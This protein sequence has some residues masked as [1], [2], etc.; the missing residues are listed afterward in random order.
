MWRSLP[1]FYPTNLTLHDTPDADKPAFGSATAG[2]LLLTDYEAERQGGW[3]KVVTLDGKS[4]WSEHR[5]DYLALSQQHLCFG[6]WTEPLRL[7]PSTPTA[8]SRGWE[9]AR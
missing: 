6:K 4:G 7:P 5:N 1:Y 3:E 8:S 9:A 2:T